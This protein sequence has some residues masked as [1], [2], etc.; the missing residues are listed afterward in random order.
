MAAAGNFIMQACGTMLLTISSDI[1]LLL[2]GCILFGL[3]VGNLVS[4]PPLI[5]QREFSP[6]DVGRAV[7]LTVAINQ[8]VFAFAPAILGLLRD[9]EGDY[10]AAFGVAAGIQL[11]AAIIVISCR[12]KSNLIEIRAG[13]ARNPRN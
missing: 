8:A 12:A 10:S 7:A 5:I 1:P 11:L 4:L 9:I 6:G 13:G 3:G 2:S